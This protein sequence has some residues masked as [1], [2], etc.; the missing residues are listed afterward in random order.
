MKNL[1]FGS[2]SSLLVRFHGRIWFRAGGW[3]G[4]ETEFFYSRVLA[5]TVV[6]GFQPTF[7]THSIVLSYYV[8]SV[9]MSDTADPFIYKPFGFPKDPLIIARLSAYALWFVVLLVQWGQAAKISMNPANRQRQG[10]FG[11]LLGGIVCLSLS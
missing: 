1:I 3:D 9:L 11:P 4:N 7:K 5:N 2:F 10:I 8:D 6:P